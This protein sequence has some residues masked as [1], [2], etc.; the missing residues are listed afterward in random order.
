M[1]QYYSD[2]PLPPRRTAP[3]ADK[4]PPHSFRAAL[5]LTPSHDRL[6]FYAEL[7]GTPAV[8]RGRGY[9][10]EKSSDP[11]GA[12]FRVPQ[13]SLLDPFLWQYRTVSPQHFKIVLRVIIPK[14]L[15]D[16]VQL[17][18][19][20]SMTDDPPLRVDVAY[21]EGVEVFSLH[22]LSVVPRAGLT[23]LMGLDDY[24]L[25]ENTLYRIRQTH[26]SELAP[27]PDGD[28]ILPLDQASSLGRLCDRASYLFAGSGVQALRDCGRGIKSARRQVTGIA[29]AAAEVLTALRRQVLDDDTDTHGS[30]LP[31]RRQPQDA[32]DAH[33]VTFPLPTRTAPTP[34]REIA[35]EPPALGR[36]VILPTP[37]SGSV[38]NAVFLNDARRLRDYAVARANFVPFRAGRPTYADMTAAQKSWYFHWRAQFHRGVV[39]KTDI[40]YIYVA[41]YELLNSVAASG[42]TALSAL[43]RLWES[44]RDAFPYLDRCMP[45]WCADYMLLN[46]LGQDFDS[47]QERIPFSITETD[48]PAEV[49]CNRRLREGLSALPL[50][51]LG[52]LGGYPILDSRFCA[53]ESRR[54]RCETA[55]ARALR[56]AEGI[57]KASGKPLL[58]SYAPMQTTYLHDSFYGAVI[59]RASSRR[60]EL[61]YRPYARDPQFRTLLAGIL[62]YTE[63]LLRKR[64]RFPGR[65][66]AE[67]LPPDIESAILNALAIPKEVGAVPPD[68][69]DKPR[70]KLVI[71]LERARALED[72]SWENTRRLLDALGTEPAAAAE[73]ETAPEPEEPPM[74]ESEETE[75]AENVP[76]MERL[77]ATQAAVLDALKRED[78]D[79]VRRICSEAMTFPDAVFEEINEIALDALGDLLIDTGMGVIYEEYKTL[80]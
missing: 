71:D 35:L 30:P 47:L 72:A 7:S 80:V 39:L 44:Y 48:V 26:L 51:V 38:K 4:T 54:A 62:R 6:F 28:S 63:N 79:A 11:A 56:A 42:A 77:N 45:G 69:P 37:I 9:F 29:S 50:S 27:Y 5:T 58:D 67:S 76:F 46:D 40:S 8:Y 14:L 41:A 55:V 19:A 73:P 22:I 49:F 1:A 34:I 32:P 75:E 78:T 59:G 52:A 61:T 17:S 36:A 70:E 65:L 33:A 16:G 23:A 60:I 2:L 18:C 3:E 43:L 66:K 74:P 10:T 68:A 12:G 25:S 21:D 20:L 13:I 15:R 31:P 64:E 24:M 53:E 57:R